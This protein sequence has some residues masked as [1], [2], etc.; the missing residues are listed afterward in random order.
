MKPRMLVD[1]LVGIAPGVERVGVDTYVN[2][3]VKV[4]RHAQQHV[5]EQHHR[6][7]QDQ[8]RA[9]HRGLGPEVGLCK[10]EHGL[11]PACCI[12]QTDTC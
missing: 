9:K 10:S 8:K 3:L 2:E 7:M 1:A 4:L 12:L 6:V 5:A 11:L